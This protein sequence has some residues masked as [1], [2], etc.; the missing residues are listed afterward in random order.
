MK[1]TI[2]SAFVASAIAFSAASV[3]APSV[4][5][6]SLN[7]VFSGTVPA[8]EV[9]SS[10]WS[11]T[12]GDG[13]PYVAPAAITMSASNG[14]E[15][16]IVMTS[17][18]E[19]LYIK[20]VSSTFTADSAIKAQLV[21]DPTLSGTAVVADQFHTVTSN[22]SIN[23]VAVTAEGLSDVVTAVAADDAAKRLVLGANVQIPSEARVAEGGDLTMQT[24]I[25]FEASIGA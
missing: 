4:T 19:T 13:T 11:F 14:E 21:I 25:R 17:A 5:E 6:G 3:A 7:F 20:P 9:V 10:D 8:K 15:G 16:A 2:V 18:N 12:N 1:K 23:G 22:V 24:T